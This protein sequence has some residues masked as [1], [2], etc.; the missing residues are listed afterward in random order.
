MLPAHATGVTDACPA[1]EEV[2]PLYLE[3]DGFVTP[4]CCYGNDVDCDRCGA[5]VVFHLAARDGVAAP[6]ASSS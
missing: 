4:Y 6:R 3:D 5:W 2:L 1:R